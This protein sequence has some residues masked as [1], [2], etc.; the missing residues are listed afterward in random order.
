M[1]FGGLDGYGRTTTPFQNAIILARTCAHAAPGP[2]L[3]S[4]GV[5][6]DGLDVHSHDVRTLMRMLLTFGAV[7]LMTLTGVDR[8][9]TTPLAAQ[10]RV[11]T[12]LTGV[13]TALGGEALLAAAKA[14]SVDGS[15]RRPTGARSTE[16]TISLLVVRPDKLRRSEETR[17]FGRTSERITTFDG[18]QAWDETVNAERGAGGGG[19]GFEHGGGGGFD[20]GGGGFDH[21]H[22]TDQFHSQD[23]ADSTGSGGI[24]TEEQINAARVRRMK[25]ELQR[26]MIALLAD[27]PQPF[28]DAG[29]AESPDGP[30]DV[31]ET[32]DEAGRLVRYFI[33]PGTHMPLMV[34][35]QEVRPQARAAQ[36][37]PKISTVAMHVS[38]YRKVDHVLM[39]HQID[40]SIDGQPSES[41]TIDR[42]KINPVVKVDA[43]RKK[44]K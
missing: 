29:R 25:M 1:V 33:D 39:P 32:K 38:D 2:V 24:L 27:S 21:N 36:T 16:G 40:I 11:A 30:A 20:R 22:E 14:V 4:A 42:F 6:Q 8:A 41:W 43:F 19:G 28:T 31:L 7:A 10:D 35:Y 26:W 15:F 44:T 3:Q 9:L 5:G 34:Q 18:T 17:F 23:Q 13:R 12:V 37:P